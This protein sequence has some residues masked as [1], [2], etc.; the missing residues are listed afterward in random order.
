MAK[1]SF[2][3]KV[4]L[5]KTIA[6][7]IT[8]DPAHRYRKLKDLLL[9]CRDPS[10]IDVVLQAVNNL[11][12][13]FIEIIPSYRIREFNEDE[14]QGENESKPSDKNDKKKRPEKMSKEGAEIRDQE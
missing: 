7:E 11:C 9:L 5:V 4:G 1:L 6:M 13:V 10:N 3:E 2:T 14:K 8:L 12:E